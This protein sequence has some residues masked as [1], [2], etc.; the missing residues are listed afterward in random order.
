[1]INLHRSAAG[2]SREPE[3]SGICQQQPKKLLDQ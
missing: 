3:P 2:V 1:M